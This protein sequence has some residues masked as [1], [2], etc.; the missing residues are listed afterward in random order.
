MQPTHTLTQ[1]PEAMEVADIGPYLKSLREH[2]RLGVED[3]AA[4]LHMRRKYIEAIEQSAF[5]ELPSPVYARG[6]IANYA[7]FLG[8][9][10]AQV[11]E[12]C[13][14]EKPLK[15]DAFFNPNPNQR[16]PSAPMK[17]WLLVAAF[18]LLLVAGYEHFFS[19]RTLNVAG[20]DA[21][22]ASHQISAVP[23]EILHRTRVQL[24]PTGAQK[25]CLLEGKELHC[26]RLYAQNTPSYAGSL[27]LAKPFHALLYAH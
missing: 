6:Y 14:G 20:G 11:V 12:K 24:M 9:N 3:V 27:V 15:K 25:S 19:Q 22:D 16:A 2:Y 7:E 1:L 8:V 13:F 4:R 10:P 23:D 21:G 17:P 26:I 5:E 18:C